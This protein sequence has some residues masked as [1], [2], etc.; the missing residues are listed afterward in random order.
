MKKTVPRIGRML[1][2]VGLLLF[3]GGGA[4]FAWSWLGF[5]RV[6]DYVP[7]AGAPPWS[8]VSLADGYWRLQK[9]GGW[10]MLAG[11]AVFL[12]AWWVAGREARQVD[13]GEEGSVADTPR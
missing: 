7:A 10:V 6:Q 2:L 5:R 3:L 11:L 4:V 13:A 8:A 9:I 1:D 12:V